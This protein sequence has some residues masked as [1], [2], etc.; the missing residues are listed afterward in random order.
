ML[1]KSFRY[2]FE[3]LKFDFTIDINED[4]PMK[5]FE[6]KRPR[7]MHFKFRVVEIEHGEIHMQMLTEEGSTREHDVSLILP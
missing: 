3:V 5:W 1:S 7:R 2:F 4:L 6:E